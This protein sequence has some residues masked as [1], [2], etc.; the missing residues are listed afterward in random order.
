MYAQESK[1]EKAVLDDGPYVVS[2][3]E[4]GFTVVWTTTAD[5]T[6]WVEIAPDTKEHFYTHERPKFYQLESGLH[7]KIGRHHTVRVTGLEKGTSYRYRIVNRT[8]TDVEPRQVLFGEHWGSDVRSGVYRT[9]T[10]DRDAD[11]VSFC[12]F[13]DIHARDTVLRSLSEHIDRSTV[14]FVVFN[15]DMVSAVKDRELIWDGYLASASE[16][17]A[18]RIPVMHVRGNHE[19]RGRCASA[20]SD[21]FPGNNSRTFYSF[22]HG[23]AM[24]IVL[25]SGED[26]SDENIAN[27]GLIDTDD[28]FAEQKE[29]LDSLVSCEEFRTAP[30]KIVLMHIPI[31]GGVSYGTERVREVFGEIL[32]NAGI[33]LMISGHNHKYTFAGSGESG[34]SFPVI[35]NDCRQMLQ[36]EV[37]ASGIHIDCVDMEG[38]AMRR[39]DL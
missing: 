27:L 6:G 23:P 29:W 34:F 9:K 19:Y 12:V 37:T 25:D 15:G 4:D 11:T 31:N 36:I 5:A 1:Y 32:D 28:L 39:L 7:Q 24:F 17:F 26:K 10:L 38:N 16:L 8:V 18:S 35:T 2:A 20:Y 13:N 3:T 33:D 22:R 30:V 21:F 14:D